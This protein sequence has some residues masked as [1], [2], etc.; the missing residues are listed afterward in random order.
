[1]LI[2]TLHGLEAM[3]RGTQNGAQAG[4][5]GEWA[6]RLGGVLR[7]LPHPELLYIAALL[8][9]TGKGRAGDHARESARMAQSVMER[10]ELDAYETG[11]VVSLIT[12]HLEMW[13]ALRR[14]IF[15]EDTV[16]AFAGNVHTPEALLMLTVFLM[17]ASTRCIRMR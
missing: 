11:L 10:L 4:T 5:K 3:Q 14:D 13:A 8:H 7:E 17:R 1:V 9:D 15:D 16:S 2:D 6:S 12:N